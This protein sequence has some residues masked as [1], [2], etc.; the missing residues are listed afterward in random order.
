MRSA[1][2]EQVYTCDVSGGLNM[3]KLKGK[4]P[5]ERGGELLVGPDE[6]L[7]FVLRE[8]I[9]FDKLLDYL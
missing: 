6:S 9:A 1:E 5:Q 8:E 7:G 2:G 4:A 3:H